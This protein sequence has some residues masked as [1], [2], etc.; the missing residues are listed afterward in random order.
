MSIIE[1]EGRAVTRSFRLDKAWDE[2]ITN[3]S[4]KRGVST[5]SMLEKL[6]RD[7]ILFYQWVE[8]LESIIFSKNTIIEII[9]A[10]DIDELRRIGRMVA[11]STFTESY[12]VRG[13]T[14]NIDTVSFQ[15]TDQMGKYAHWFTVEEHQTN[16][17][18][19]Y[20][21]HRLGEKWSAFV[22]AYV[23]GMIEDVAGIS[24]TTERVGENILVKLRDN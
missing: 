20:I 7:Y 15:I 18:Y 2:A 16:N 12:L 10:V 9:N 21:M 6:V 13:D 5:S 19:F 4:D 11:K 24:V 22:E 14:L 3:I 17:H 1:P 23:V 8:E